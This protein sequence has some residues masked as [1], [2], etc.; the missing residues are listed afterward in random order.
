MPMCLDEELAQ[1]TAMLPGGWTLHSVQM[2]PS[3]GYDAVLLRRDRLL[4]GEPWRVV[5]SGR[6]VQLAI[7][8]VTGR[9]RDLGLAKVK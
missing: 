9:F 6:T 8:D 1:L 4:P 2:N 7:S 3:R 5:G